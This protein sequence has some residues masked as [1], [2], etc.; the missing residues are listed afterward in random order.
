M[1]ATARQSRSVL[2]PGHTRSPDGPAVTLADRLDPPGMRP[3][4]ARILAAYA[5]YYNELRTHLTS[6]APVP[7]QVCADSS[8]DPAARSA[9]REANLRGLHHQYCRV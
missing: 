9:R 5:G 2:Q 6:N 1:D 8:T 7:G 3:T 4:C